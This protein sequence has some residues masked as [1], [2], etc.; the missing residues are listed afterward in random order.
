MFLPLQ[1]AAVA[2]LEGPLDSVKE[3]CQMYEERRDALCQGLQRHWLGTFKWKRYHV[4]GQRSR[5]A[6][7][8]AWHLYGTDGKAGVIV[9]PKASFGP[10]GEGYVRF[11]R[12]YFPPEEDPGS[13]GS[14]WEQRNYRYKMIRGDF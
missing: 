5:V 11:A 9:T 13:S 12:L 4:R 10:H 6:A 8:T 7:R 1:K 14:D 2:A 3:Q